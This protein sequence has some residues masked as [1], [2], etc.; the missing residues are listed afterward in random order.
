[1]ALPL[2]QA[3][4]LTENLCVS[5]VLV[6][7]DPLKL[8]FLALKLLFHIQFLAFWDFLIF[9]P[10]VQG[11]KIE[12]KCAGLVNPKGLKYVARELQSNTI[13]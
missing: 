11:L 12:L 2:W 10:E 8:L 1:M 7:W 13:Q 4:E 3:V 5:P 9:I 6:S